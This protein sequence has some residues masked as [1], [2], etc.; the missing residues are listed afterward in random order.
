MQFCIFFCLYLQC[1]ICADKEQTVNKIKDIINRH[2]NAELA[3]RQNQ[4]EVIQQRITKVRKTMHMLR[5]VLV[6]SYYNNKN[7]VLNAVEDTPGSSDE[8]PMID[9]QNRIHP[10]VKKLLGKNSIDNFTYLASRRNKNKTTA[11]NS[12]SQESSA[13]ALSTSENA[14]ISER[15]TFKC[16]V[17]EESEVKR[18]VIVFEDKPKIEAKGAAKVQFCDSIRNRKK[19]KYRVV[20]GNISKWMPS[21]SQ[22]DNSTHKWMMYVR[23]TKDSPSVSHFIQKVVFYLHPSYKPNDVIELK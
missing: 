5:Y 8:I 20:I 4:L 15:L 23:G 13:E 2:F 19:T 7:C 14:D 10:A 1:I 17:L 18:N 16:E 3:H 21:E 12:V 11:V 9:P 22:E 6:T